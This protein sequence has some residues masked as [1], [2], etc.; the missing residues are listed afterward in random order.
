MSNRSLKELVVATTNQGKLREIRRL[1]VQLPIEVVSPKDLLGV[2]P[3]IVEDGERFED[4]ALIKARAIAQLTQRVT[5]ADDSGL[6]VDVLGGLPGVRSARYAGEQ[7]TDAENNDALVRALKKLGVK[8]ATARFR[9]SMALVDS[10]GTV[11]GLHHGV[12]EGRVILEP[13]GTTG[14][15]YDPL[16]VVTEL[17][18]RTMAEL[19]DDE[20][21][22][23]SHR[24]RALRS[25]L[26][27]LERLVTTERNIEVTSEL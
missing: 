1:L 11:L 12:C 24:G 27:E 23:I 18:E 17:G 14:F 16:F 7:A 6:E 13:R 8:E 20:K 4:N 2:M 22:A 19:T 15:G 26:N 5:L 9:C 3:H 25:L 21:N 10:T